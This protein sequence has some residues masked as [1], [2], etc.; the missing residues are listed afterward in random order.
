MSLRLDLN[1]A[2]CGAFAFSMPLHRRDPGEPLYT[3]AEGQAA[4]WVCK[5]GGQRVTAAKVDD[6]EPQV[7][8]TG[9]LF[10]HMKGLIA[11]Q[12][13]AHEAEKAQMNAR[14]R[15]RLQVAVEAARHEKAGDWRNWRGA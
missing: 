8:G 4:V 5:C 11:K 1:C 6:D 3:D 10:E 12:R 7:Q 14:F 13:L 2:D 15:R 9:D